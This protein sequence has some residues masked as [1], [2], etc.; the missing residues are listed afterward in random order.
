MTLTNIRPLSPS[1][2]QDTRDWLGQIVK[3][4]ART[5]ITTWDGDRAG[6]LVSE[7]APLPSHIVVR[8]WM[9]RK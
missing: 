3:T 9:R 2:L 8:E 4:Q 1:Q 6:N 7:N 5:L